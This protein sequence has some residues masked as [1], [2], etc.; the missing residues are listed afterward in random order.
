MLKNNMH[1]QQ[2]DTPHASSVAQ[3]N[4]T[5]AQAHETRVGIMYAFGCYLWW[6][7]VAIYFKAIAHVA[8]PEILAHRIVWSVVLLALLMKLKGRW[9]GAMAAL[10]RPGVVVSLLGSTTF[11]AINWFTFIWAVAHNQIVQA[12]LGYFINPLVSVLLG[13]I[14]LGERLR[15]SQWLSVCLAAGGVVFMTIGLGGLPVVSLI[16]AFSFGLYGLMR[17]TMHVDSLVGLTFEVSLLAPLAV[18]Y[19]T[20]LAWTQHLVFGH[21]TRST[22]VLLALG[23]VITAVPLLWFANAARR[24]RLATMGFM[25]YM[26]P[27]MQLVIG[28]AMYHEPFTRTHLISFGLIWT[29]IAV[30]T[31]EAMIKTR[32][33]VVV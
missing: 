21:T 5:S 7:F 4:P 22:D 26:A 17:K 30:Y 10:R 2:L 14:F 31:Y 11:I 15:T 29:G 25:Q 24:L 6:G 13:Y 23:G 32:R 20:Y 3:A 18:G 16:L 33:R 28:V 19:L 27:S 12:S 9:P 1:E 8:A